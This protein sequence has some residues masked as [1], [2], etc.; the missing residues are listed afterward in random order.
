MTK[1]PPTNEFH[2]MIL[3]SQA[4][5]PVDLV[6]IANQSNQKFHSCILKSVLTLVVMHAFIMNHSSFYHLLLIHHLKFQKVRLTAMSF[7]EETSHSSD[8]KRPS[9][10]PAPTISNHKLRSNAESFRRADGSLGEKQPK[11]PTIREMEDQRL[12]ILKRVS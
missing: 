12:K 8:D 2:T 5:I 10:A 9:P 1:K 3:H 7:N 6:G 11:W 4:S